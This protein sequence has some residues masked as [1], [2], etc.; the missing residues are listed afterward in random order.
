MKYCKKLSYFLIF[1][2]FAITASFAQ[3]KK[4]E[5]KIENLLSKMIL[6]EKI[7]QMNQINGRNPS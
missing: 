3:D 6:R 7:G 5:D 2:C 4:I 1:S